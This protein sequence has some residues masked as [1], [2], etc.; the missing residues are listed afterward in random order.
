MKD[1]TLNAHISKELDL[2]EQ[3]CY[4]EWFRDSLHGARLLW[5][6]TPSVDQLSGHMRC[7]HAGTGHQICASTQAV[8]LPSALTDPCSG[9]PGH[10]STVGVGVACQSQEGPPTPCFLPLPFVLTLP[11]NYRLGTCPPWEIEELDTNL[12]GENNTFSKF[13]HPEKISGNILVIS[14]AIKKSILYIEGDF[15]GGEVARDHILHPTCLFIL[16]YMNKYF[17]LSIGVR[18]TWNINTGVILFSID[19]HTS[20]FFIVVRMLS[21]N[22]VFYLIVIRDRFSC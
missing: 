4:E 17:L 14:L 2:A 6:K 11:S 10:G 1:F 8:L 21:F 3:D 12:K 15:S 20:Y 16:C 22:Q 9:L 18:R 13:P 7:W 19:P 5:E